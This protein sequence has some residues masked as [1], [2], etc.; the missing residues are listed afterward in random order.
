[1]NED[2]YT[3]LLNRQAGGVQTTGESNYWWAYNSVYS[4]WRRLEEDK[5]DETLRAEDQGFTEEQDAALQELF[6]ATLGYQ[7]NGSAERRLKPRRLVSW[8]PVNAYKPESRHQWFQWDDVC[9]VNGDNVLMAKQRC[10]SW[11][12][13][14]TE[15]SHCVCTQEH[16]HGR[17]CQT[18]TCEE[19]DV[20]LFSVLF[21][22]TESIDPYVKGAEKEE[23]T[24]TSFDR[25][26]RCTSWTGDI[27]AASMP[28]WWR[29]VSPVARA[30]TNTVK[31]VRRFPAPCRCSPLAKDLGVHAQI[32]LAM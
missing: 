6:P 5:E 17:A 8:P 25:D 12:E 18:W 2:R 3:D 14:E 24:C 22:T 19:R 23:Y 27:V 10:N 9:I 13:I 16:H 26:D 11:R 21:R 32:A 29:V 1:M 31:I 15:I 4:N 28:V 30:Y 7:A 20:G